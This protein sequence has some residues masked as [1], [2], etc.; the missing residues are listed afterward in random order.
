MINVAP[1]AALRVQPMEG[2]LTTHFSFSAS[3]SDDLETPTSA[4]WIRWD[5]HGD[6]VWDHDW[7]QALQTTF[8]YDRPGSYITRVRVR[9]EAGPVGAM[10]VT[11]LVVDTPPLPVLQMWVDGAAC[12]N[13][14]L[15]RG[16]V[17]FDA[18]NSSDFEDPLDELRIRW[19]FD[20][21]ESCDT[22]WGQ[23]FQ[24]KHEFSIPGNYSLRIEL[25]DTSGSVTAT[26]FGYTVT[27]PKLPAD[28][29]ASQDEW[30]LWGATAL[31]VLSLA[32]ASWLIIGRRR[33]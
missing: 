21:D 24:L 11:V 16:Q 3:G 6:G 15:V 31:L 28:P 19:D 4:L 5:F 1:T 12:G 22:D 30:I 7:T 32:T 26:E 13:P 18:T 33:P 10:N 9:D 2:N 27:A 23:G 14:C 25:R 20:G 29:Q 17:T 8:Q